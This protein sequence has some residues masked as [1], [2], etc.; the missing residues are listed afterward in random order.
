[1]INGETKLLGLIGWPVSHSCSPAM[2]NRAL[3]KLGL[4]YV[5]VPLPVE[6]AK[7]PEAVAGLKAIHF[8]GFNVTI[9]H[10]VAI[11]KYLDRVHDTARAIGAVNTV[12]VRQGEWVGYNTDGE[13]FIRS[14]HAAG[15]EVKG[16]HAVL[17]GAGGAARAILH[18]LLAHGASATVVAR[19][20]AKARQ[21]ADSLGPA[22][23]CV[24]T[25]HW[26]SEECAAALARCDLCINCTPIGMVPH[27]DAM[28]P[29]ELTDIPRQAV[30][31]DVV[32]NPPV[33]AFLAE[34]AR[35]GFRTVTGVGM[36]VHQGALA[37]E[38]WTGHHAPLAVMEKAVQA[39]LA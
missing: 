15:V 4:N 32:Y 39:A 31:C 35:L 38:L 25:C 37:L 36:L 21:M 6:P 2:H 3:Q 1:M 18:A 7:L 9:P 20:P 12:V 28:P 33:T 29:I 14:L 19:Q 27:A 17:L 23:R 5:Y 26:D 22:S 24:V 30:I 13:G 11:I 16:G 8:C 10:K 34:A